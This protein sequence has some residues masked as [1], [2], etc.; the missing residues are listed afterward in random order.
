[1]IAPNCVRWCLATGVVV[2]L[3]S[4]F[5]SA[6]YDGK[7]SKGDKSCT[8]KFKYDTENGLD[9]T[10]ISQDCAHSL[11]LGTKK[12]DGTFEAP[13]GTPEIKPNNGVYQLWCFPDVTIELTDSEGNKCPVKQ[14]VYVAKDQ[15][16]G[17]KVLADK[18]I[19]NQHW[20]NEAKACQSGA[21][22]KAKGYWNP[23]WEPPPKKKP[24]EKQQV[25]VPPRNVEKYQ[26]SWG[27]PG[28]IME[29]PTIHEPESK[30]SYLP[31]SVIDQL[32][33]PPAGPMIHVPSA[34]PDGYEA[35][36]LG[37]FVNNGQEFFQPF[38]LPVFDTGLGPVQQGIV[39]AIDDSNCSV[40]I[41]GANFMQ[42]YL[43][44]G[45]DAL[46]GEF[47]LAYLAPTQLMV[48]EST[49]DRVMLFDPW[50][51][52]LINPNFINLTVSG[53]STPINAIQVGSEIWVSDQLTD[54]IMR[55]SHDGT[56]HLGNL[57]GGL[58][59][60]RGIEI[61]GNTV[62]VSNS[63]TANG[64]PGRAVVTIDV[65]SQSITGFFRVGDDLNGDPFDVLAYNTGLLVNDI[66]GEDIE[67]HDLAGN[68]LFTFHDSDGINGIDFP[69][70]M[71]VTPI[72]SVLAAGF[73][74]PIGVFHYDP[75]G[76]Q[77][78][79]WPV[80]NGNRGVA[81]LGNGTILYTDGNGVH[82]LNPQNGQTNPVLTGVGGRFI[83]LRTEP[84]L[85]CYPDCEEDGDLDVF[86]FLCFMN[87]H[88]AQ[89]PYAD[90]EEDGDW[91]VFDFL[92]FLNHYGLGCD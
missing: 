2:L 58:D 48:V 14:T 88:A 38:H 59:N 57:T 37:F 7:A 52:S 16:G 72:N 15:N 82:V 43:H 73:S 28:Q 87:R 47:L 54:R 65:P 77:V 30:H 25:P 53:A 4:A 8:A 6:S 9:G 86:D 84:P 49:L 17:N 83:D 74:P 21:G 40:A 63:G 24:I 78:N 39:L 90:C 26:G 80:G 61:V 85:A 18:N 91:D 55:W 60:I 68:W 1:M 76:N 22:A 34:D 20:I 69:E 5:A 29:M 51:G 45:S 3:T 92:C 35:L 89:D 66:A 75:A 62:Y 11:G 64:A 81:T 44:G 56:T 70:Q 67:F 19:V 71:A 50:D 23:G 46:G 79:F 41:S 32:G 36:Q 13:A 42:D 10:V 33:L 27:K 12:A 31:Q